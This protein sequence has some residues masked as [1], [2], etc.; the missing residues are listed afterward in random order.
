MKPGKIILTENPNAKPDN[1][2]PDFEGR[3]V[4]PEGALYDVEVWLRRC[5]NNPDLI[6]QAGNV[7][8]TP[9]CP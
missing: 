5:K 1:T 2:E 8:P 7:T 9:P 4:T 3:L 6:F